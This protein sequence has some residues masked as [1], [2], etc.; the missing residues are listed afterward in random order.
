[1]E[2]ISTAS[3]GLLGLHRELL[4]ALPAEELVLLLGFPERHDRVILAAE[5]LREASELFAA[6][7]DHDNCMQQGTKAISLY[8]ALVERDKNYLELIRPKKY[9][10]LLQRLDQYPATTHL[11]EQRRR[12]ARI[13]SPDSATS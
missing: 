6:L 5:L 9:A 13:T 1:L 8:C 4:F 2:E 11:N 7:G 12:F 10:E 3:Q